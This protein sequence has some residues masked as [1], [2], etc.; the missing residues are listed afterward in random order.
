MTDVTAIG[1]LLIDFAATGVDERGYPQMQANAGGAPCN[2]LA[3]LS[4]YGRRTAFI[5]KVGDDAFGALLR[6]TLEKAGIDTRAL[7]TDAR[8][9]TT[10]AFVT[11]DEGGD[12]SFSFARKPGA[13]TQ[14]SFDEIDLSLIDETAVLHFG[15]LSLTDEPARTA[16]KRTVEYAIGR[17]KL[18]SFDPNLRKPLWK[19]EDEARE[20][21]LW[22]LR[23]ADVVKISD[24]EIDLL[25]GCTPAEGARRLTDEFG[26]SLVYATLGSRGSIIRNARCEVSVPVPA[27]TPVD[28]TGA[29]D[30]FGGSAM[31]KLLDMGRSPAALDAEEL[32]EIGL[33][34][35]CAASLSTQRQGGIPSIPELDAVEECVSRLRE[36][37]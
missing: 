23:H 7:I 8:Y 33:F 31:K 6:G 27:V 36:S 12:R 24:E 19:S 26:V 21:M 3:A 15:T 20:Q 2:L 18:I 14:L 32:R 11:F 17:G 22:G 13:D 28:T 9:F 25:F 37:I 10:L 29:G 30:I 35:S 4:K 16:T 5:G 34:A 1:E